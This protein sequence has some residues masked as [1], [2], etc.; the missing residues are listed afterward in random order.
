MDINHESGTQHTYLKRFI[1][2]VLFL[3]IKLGTHLVR[4]MAYGMKEVSPRHSDA[5]TKIA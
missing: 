1:H 4:R 3:L 5:N 2:G